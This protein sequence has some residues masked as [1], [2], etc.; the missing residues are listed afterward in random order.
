MGSVAPYL[1]RFLEYR[2]LNDAEIGT[3]Q[4][5]GGLA[6]LVTPALMGL[7]ADLKFENKTLLAWVFLATAISQAL[8]LVCFGFW[9][10]LIVNCLCSLSFIPALS[11]QDGLTFTQQKRQ[12]DAGA[13]PVPYHRVR[14]WGTLGFIAP[15]LVLYGLME[16]MGF[17][18]EMTLVCAAFAALL[19]LANTF[20]LPHTRGKFGAPGPLSETPDPHP[21]VEPGEGTPTMQAL[22]RMMQP[23]I[24]VFCI[25]LWLMQLAVGAYY[26]FYPIYMT[27]QIGVRDAWLG[28]ISS[29]GVVLEVFFI[30]LFGWMIKRFGLKRLMTAC[31]LLIVVRM[32]LLAFVPNLAVAVGTQVLH[33][34]MVLAMHV[35]PPL[36]LNH[37]AQPAFRNSMQSLYTM[38]VYGSGRIVGSL[39]GGVVAQNSAGGVLSVFAWATL[40]AAVSFVLFAI[41]FRDHTTDRM[42]P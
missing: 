42:E 35:A 20:F 26:S 8:M 27:R 7:L 5:L 6:V 1:A 14:V 13:T 34:M 9:T 39:L 25:S 38:L 31:L 30:L 41:G 32:A 4:G 21:P 22:R 33:G 3:V 16:W 29:V 11:L 2:G 18:I 12:R 37:R 19:T 23:D 36:Y 40:I 15:S 17:S 10:L 28:P 24:L